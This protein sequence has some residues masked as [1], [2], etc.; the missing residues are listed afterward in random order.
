MPKVKTKKSAAKRFKITKTG[1]AKHQRA[2]G[3]HLATGKAG[4]RKRFLK[5]ADV[6]SAAHAYQMRRMLPTSGC[7]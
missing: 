7:K 2:F 1:K 5:K 4:K 6:V 3:G